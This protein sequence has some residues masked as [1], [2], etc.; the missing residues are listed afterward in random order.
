MP[1]HLYIDFDHRLLSGQT[2]KFINQHGCNILGAPASRQHQNGLVERQWQ[3]LMNMARSF[4][5]NKKIPRSFWWW[6]I[7]HSCQIINYFPCTVEGSK[8]SPLELVF[9]VKPDFSTLLPIFSTTYFRHKTDR[10]R[11]RDGTEAK[12]LQAILLGRAEEADGHLLYSPYTKEFYVSGDVKIDSGSCTASAFNLKYDGGLFLGLYDSSHV[13]NGTEPYPPGTSIL[14]TLENSS[15]IPG[16]V[17]PSP[18]PDL[19]KGFPSPSSTSQKYSIK[20]HIGELNHL[21]HSGSITMQK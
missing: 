9:G 21:F 4:L 20:L 17:T 8:T 19:D 5:S 1:C 2:E 16:T 11:I 12:V 6:A 15:P 13:S 18:L 14:C 3:T 7:R 10:T